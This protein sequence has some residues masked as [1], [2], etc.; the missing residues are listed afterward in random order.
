MGFDIARLDAA[1]L[2]AIGIDLSF[3]MLEQAR[4]RVGS[5][6]PLIRA[7]AVTLPLRDASV[8][9]CRIERVL[10]HVADPNA[11]VNEIARVVRPGGFLAALEPDFGTFRVDSHVAT[12][13][14]VPARLLRARH[15]QIGAELVPM[16]SHAGFRVQ[17]VVTESSRGYRLD[18]LPV[19]AEA[20]IR[21]A[22]ADGRFDR[23]DA[24]NW[25]REQ[26]S[27]TRAGTFRASWDKVLVIATRV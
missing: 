11:V 7:D 15:P 26:R 9:G 17:D 19:S 22:V 5:A 25:L 27:R 23:N 10:E 20:V 12:D 8:D 21:R 6:A 4:S 24:E 13:G 3:Q 1:G 14:D 18:G 16:L 2:S